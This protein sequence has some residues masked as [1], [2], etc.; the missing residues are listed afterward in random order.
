MVRI[1]DEG[2]VS[3]CNCNLPKL[4]VIHGQVSNGM[5]CGGETPNTTNQCKELNPESLE[6]EEWSPMNKKRT[7]HAMTTAGNQTRYICGGLDVSIHHKHRSAILQSCEKFDGKWS[8]IKDLPIPLAGHCMIE[9]D[10]LIYVIGGIY[11]IRVIIEK[12]KNI[13]IFV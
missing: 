1:S 6:W 3:T 11:N 7:F 4:Q 12:L 8:F 2:V 9:T 10:D 13:Q 5:I